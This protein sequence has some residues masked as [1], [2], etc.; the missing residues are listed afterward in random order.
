[1][2]VWCLEAT[3]RFSLRDLAMFPLPGSYRSGRGGGRRCRVDGS[4]AGCLAWPQLFC[5]NL[6]PG[7]R[8][9]CDAT[10]GRRGTGSGVDFVWPN[11]CR[12]RWI[13]LGA[14]RRFLSSCGST[15]SRPGSAFEPV[16]HKLSRALELPRDTAAAA[17]ISCRAASLGRWVVHSAPRPIH[18]VWIIC[19]QNFPY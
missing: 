9:S 13:W 8:E 14:R 12:E 16:R 6:R 7:T 18:L 15:S 11:E 10:T 3:V 17:L 19:F 2:R 5:L 4:L 1:M